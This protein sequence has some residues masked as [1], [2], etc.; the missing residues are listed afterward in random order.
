MDVLTSDTRWALNNEIKKRQVTSSLSLF[1]Y[2]DDA[3][4]NKHKT[5][6][7]SRIPMTGLR[8][9]SSAREVHKFHHSPHWL[10]FRM[11]SGRYWSIHLPYLWSWRIPARVLTVGQWGTSWF[12][13]LIWD[14][15]G[16]PWR[17]GWA[18]HV[19]HMGE[20][21]G[22]YKVSLGKYQG[23]TTFVRPRRNMGE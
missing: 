1:N 2:Q 6:S 20:R 14:Y 11:T 13:F 5:Q 21:R 23:K 12:A 8:L 7:Y 19:V 9:R 15:Q 10:P 3:R 17:M 18:G 16:D 4:S 22:A